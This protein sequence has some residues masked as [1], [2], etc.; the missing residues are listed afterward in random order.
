V[1]CNAFFAAMPHAI[2]ALRLLHG[3]ARAAAIALIGWGVALAGYQGKKIPRRFSDAYHAALP[4]LVEL[5][6]ALVEQGVSPR[7]RPWLFAAMAAGAGR[8]PEALSIIDEIWA[9][10][11]NFRV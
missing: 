4:D 7:Y 9:S 11:R 8:F 10:R 1:I 3:A 5:S 2:A 6:S